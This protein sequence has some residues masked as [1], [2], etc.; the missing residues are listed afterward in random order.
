MTEVTEEEQ[1]M[2][3]LKLQENVRELIRKEIKEALQDSS[4]I[5]SIYLH[6]FAARVGT[7]LPTD[8]AFTK[9][10]YAAIASR[11]SQGY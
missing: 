3:A 9:S 5:H 7:Y 8:P 6:H 1:A 2:M 11:L 4:F 10:L